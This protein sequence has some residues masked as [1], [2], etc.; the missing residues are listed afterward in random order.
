MTSAE[1][2]TAVLIV[3]GGLAGLTSALLLARQGVRPILAERQPETSLLPQARAFNPRSMEI[4]RGLGLEPLIRRHTSRLAEHPE[5]IGAATLAGAERFRIDLLA[6]VRPPQD[7][8]PTD[9]CMIDQD[10]L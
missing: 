1:E 9:W 4:Y 3:G 7:V 8:S 2:G 10:E 6:E 5:M